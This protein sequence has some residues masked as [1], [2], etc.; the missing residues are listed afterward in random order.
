MAFLETPAMPRALSLGVEFAV[1]F[2][3]EIA[4][5]DSGHES[6]N[7]GRGGVGLVTGELH[8]TTLAATDHAALLDFVR[9][10]KGQGHGFRCRNWAD[11]QV[12]QANGL[13]LA[14]A[15]NPG[16][17]QLTKRHA[18]GALADDHAIYKP[19][20]APKIYRNAILQTAGGA[21]GNYALDATRGRVSFVANA[22]KTITGITQANPGVLTITAH[23]FPAGALVGVSDVSGMTQINGQSGAVTVID[24]DHVSIGIDTT[25]YG[26]YTSGGTAAQYGL[27]ADALTWEGEFDLPV[28]FSGRPRARIVQ[29]RANGDFVVE[30]DDAGIIEL[31]EGDV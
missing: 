31:L 11:Y 16:V 29:K 2:D 1:D 24:A 22:T 20:G 5:D 14:I 9:A 28:R 4:I 23:G 30:W 8:T 13:L 26:A 3:I 7:I 25:A 10:V 21:P 15:A 18:A 19:A 27:A 6:R 17:Y 12:T